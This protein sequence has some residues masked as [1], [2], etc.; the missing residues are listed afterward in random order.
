MR[1]D[2]SRFLYATSAISRVIELTKYT[3]K[4]LSDDGEDTGS[5]PWTK[6]SARDT[7]FR[8]LIPAAIHPAAGHPA[9]VGNA[10]LS[11]RAC[12]AGPTV[13]SRHPPWAALL[14]SGQNGVVLA[15]EG[16]EVFLLLSP[17]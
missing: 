9:D 15:L 2:L 5:P 13:V 3:L 7:A 8:G 6:L 12:L 16:N 17:S 4:L 1:A 10:K 14:N 11:T